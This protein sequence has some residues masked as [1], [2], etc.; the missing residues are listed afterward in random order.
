MARWLLAVETSCTGPSRGK[1]FNEW[2]D[3]I[4]LAD[5]LKLPRIASGTRYKNSIAGEGQGKYLAPYEMDTEDMKQTIAALPHNVGAMSR[6]SVPTLARRDKIG[7]I[8]QIYFAV[9]WGYPLGLSGVSLPYLP[10]LP[11]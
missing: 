4:H 11:A 6:D 2:H 9:P 1:E 10:A 3:N 5:G 8:S 7:D